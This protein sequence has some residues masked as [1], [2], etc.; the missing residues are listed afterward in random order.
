MQATIVTIGDELLIGQVVDT[1]AAW[2]GEQ[3][4]LMG[5][6]VACMVTLGDD[7][8]AIARELARAWAATDLVLVTGG[9]GPT[10][11]DVTRAAVARFA[12]RPLV[13]HAD[14]YEQIAARFAAR[15]RSI[16]ASNRTQAMVP[17]GFEVLP[18]PVGTA[19][20][21]WFEAA[22]EGRERVLVVLPGVP[23]EMRTLMREQVLPRL[24]RREGLGVIVHRTLL[25]AGIGESNLQEAIGDLGPYLGPGQRL[26]FLPGSGGVRL[27]L[28]G[29]GD[30]RAA[31]EARLAELEAYLRSRIGPYLYGEGDDTLEAVVGR[32]L[33]ARGLTIAAAES[34]TGGHVLNRLTNVSGSS[35]YVVGGIVAYSN[36][37]KIGWLGVDPAVI[38]EQ[39][40]VCE[41]CALQ[42]ARGVRERFGADIGVSTTG[43]A[44]PT[45]GTPDKPVGTVWLGYADAEGNRAVQMHFGVDRLINKERSVT[46]LLDLVRRQVLRAGA[47]TAPD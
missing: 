11:D 18:N 10:H 25:T 4:S 35:A 42:M 26:A 19:P 36:A 9:L 44:G 1:N 14:V 7:E 29:L 34:C 32:L 24:G 27:R 5:V 38:E 31:V 45:G 15:G 17:E 23:H 28:T 37:V 21:L 20:G 47:T 12:G 33:K 2:I 39:G 16:P 40:A 41:A 13:F 6:S 43:V 46:A 8:D 30:D 3:L 22:V